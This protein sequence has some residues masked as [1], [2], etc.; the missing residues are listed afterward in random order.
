MRLHAVGVN[1]SDT[2]RR[3]GVYDPPALPWIPGNEAAGVVEALG[4]GVDPMWQ[5]RRVAFW[6]MRTSGAYAEY[7][8]APAAA[9]FA[10]RDDID[11][12]LE[13]PC[14]R[15]DSRPTAS[16]TWPRLLGQGR[17]RYTCGRRWSGRVARAAPAE[18][19]CPGLRHASHA[20]QG[21]AA[22]ARRPAAVLR[23]EPGRPRRDATA[24]WAWT[25]CPIRWDRTRAPKLPGP[26]RATV[27][28]VYFGGAERR[29]GSD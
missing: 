3:R 19:R 4:A 13:W 8:A 1:F 25:P 15:R 23:G 16:P 10:L 2:E 6:A 18:A 17:P 28:L 9:L 14:R 22:V 11:F 12:P 29:S 27:I 21:A 24:A 26:G 5:G 20:G 7:A